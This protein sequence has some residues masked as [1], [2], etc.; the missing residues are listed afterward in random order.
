VLGEVG[1]SSRLGVPSLI[2]AGDG[3]LLLQAIDAANVA[4]TD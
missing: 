2:D 4:G 3:W 1:L